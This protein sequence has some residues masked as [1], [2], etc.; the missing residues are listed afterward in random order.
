MLS[1]SIQKSDVDLRKT[2]YSNIVLSGG[3]TLFK[4]LMLSVLFVVEFCFVVVSFFL[5]FYVCVCGGGGGVVVLGGVKYVMEDRLSPFT[6]IF[7]F[8]KA[9]TEDRMQ[10][11][12]R[13]QTQQ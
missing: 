1:Y 11:P 7:N 4:G 10:L 12:E 8:F 3:S 2:L 13:Q 5:L 9:C 6:V